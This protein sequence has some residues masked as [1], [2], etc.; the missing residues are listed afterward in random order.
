[1]KAEVK[2]FF[3]TNE[4]ED[5]TYQNLGDTFKAV[6]TGKYIAMNAHM[7]SKERSKIDTL[8]SKLKEL[9]EQDQKNLKS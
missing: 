4:N 6:S 7:S 5:T 3:E 9:E 1:M 8:S 2:K